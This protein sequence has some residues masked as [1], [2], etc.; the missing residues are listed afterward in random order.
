MSRSQAMKESQKR[1][2][3]RRQL[4]GIQMVKKYT[5]QAHIKHDADI[6]SILEKQSNVNAYLKELVR[7]DTNEK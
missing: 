2:A 6:I 3:E 1:Y 5:L 4:A 7:K